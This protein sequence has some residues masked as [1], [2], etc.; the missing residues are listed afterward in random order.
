MSA[1]P[2]PA[3]RRK[4]TRQDDGGSGDGGG[5]GDGC[6]MIRGRVHQTNLIMAPNLAKDF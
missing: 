2:K 3:L 4:I 5:D 6:V 1:S